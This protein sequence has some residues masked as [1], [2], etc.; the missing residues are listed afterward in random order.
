MIQPP[1]KAATNRIASMLLTSGAPNFLKSHNG[2]PNFLTAFNDHHITRNPECRQESE[3]IPIPS[4]GVNMIVIDWFTS[5]PKTI[6]PPPTSDAEIAG[7]V[8]RGSGLLI[9]ILFSRTTK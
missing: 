2:K 9:K 5:P 8:N 3:K 4:L 1:K 7:I 6:K